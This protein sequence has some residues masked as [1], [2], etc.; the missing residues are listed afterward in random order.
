MREDRRAKPNQTLALKSSTYVWHHV[1]SYLRSKEMMVCIGD[2]EWEQHTGHLHLVLSPWFESQ[3]LHFLSSFLLTHSLGGDWWRLWCEHL[4]AGWETQWSPGSWLR[5]GYC[6]IW[7][8]NQQ[9]K[10]LSL[11]AFMSLCLPNKVKKKKNPQKQS[12]DHHSMVSSQAD[13]RKGIFFL[14]WNIFQC[15]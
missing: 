10:D 11:S 12:I 15:Q 9:M 5:P 2:S 3:L 14:T 8:K 13:L 4:S 1:H 7:R 6:G